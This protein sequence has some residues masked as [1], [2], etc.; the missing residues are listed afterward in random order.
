MQGFLSKGGG[1]AT[2]FFETT[3]LT[4]SANALFKYCLPSNKKILTG[5]IARVDSKQIGPLENFGKYN[6]RHV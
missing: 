4:M 1:L 6:W 3:A 2:G 5:V